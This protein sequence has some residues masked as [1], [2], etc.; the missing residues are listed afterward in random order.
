MR[1]EHMTFSYATDA[2]ALEAFQLFIYRNFGDLIEYYSDTGTGADREIK[3]VIP[4]VNMIFGVKYNQLRI[5]NT[6][7]QVIYTTGISVRNGTF[8]AINFDGQIALMSGGN[9]ILMTLK[10]DDGTPAIFSISS[11]IYHGHVYSTAKDSGLNM[12]NRTRLGAIYSTQVNG[13]VKNTFNISGALDPSYPIY[14]RLGDELLI[15]AGTGYAIHQQN[16]GGF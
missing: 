5:F 7:G 6:E 9:A 10:I 14:M 13:V 12:S 4:S 16:K 2:D 3:F 1:V 11:L 8:Q 15:T